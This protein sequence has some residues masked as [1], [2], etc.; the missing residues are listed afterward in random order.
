[1]TGKFYS[2]LALSAYPF[3]QPGFLQKDR[4]M[5]TEL[6]TAHTVD[7]IFIIINRGGISGINGLHR[8]ALHTDIAVVAAGLQNR[9]PNPDIGG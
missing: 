3:G 6:V 7:A 9:R 5:G 4:I 2:L 8:T 1:M